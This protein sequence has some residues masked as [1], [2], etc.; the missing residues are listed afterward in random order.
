MKKNILIALQLLS[1]LVLQAQTGIGTPSPDP[2]SVLELKST[3]RGFLP[4]RMTTNQRNTIVS[5]ATG[6]MIYNSDK[7][8]LEWYDGTVWY[9]GCGIQESSGGSAVVSGYSCATASAGTLTV[10]TPVSGVTQTIT[11]AVATVGSY[12]ISAIANGVT[13][14][15]SGTFAGTGAQNIVL[16]ATGTPIAAETSSFILNTSPV[17]NFSRVTNS[18]T[19]NGS[20]VVSGYSCAT[21]SAGTLTAG[22]AATGVTQ[23]ITATVGTVGTYSIS[24]I[25]NG[26]TFAGSGTFAGTGAQNVVLTATGTPTA[27]ETSSFVLNTSPV[28]NFSRVTNSTTSNGSAVVSGYS[29]SAASAGAMTAGTAV[30]GVTQTITATVTTVGTYSISAIANGVTFADS[31]TFTGTGAQNVVLT[32]TGIPVAAETS[33]FILSIIPNC[34]F[35]RVITAAVANAICDGSVPTVV[36]PI[37]STTGKVWMDR[38]LGASRAATSAT[39]YQ[40]YGGL[41]QWGRG[42]DGHASITWISSTEGMAV[43]VTTAILAITD[44]PGNALFI[45]SIGALAY[46]WRSTQNNALW[47]GAAGINN[48]C[49][50][51]YR[52][53]TDAELTAEVTAYGITNYISA[54]ASPHK[55]V[56]AGRRRSDG[57]LN[58]AGGQSYY[59]SSTVSGTNASIRYFLSG[60]AG[61]FADGRTYGF[62]VRCLKD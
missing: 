45:T 61:S 60:S 53:P 44:S 11:A 32:G 37:T 33:S 54:Y 28:C 5:P 23:T 57:A 10:G 21:D 17:C 43:N 34:S 25:A 47:Q 13:F 14:K 62:S 8:C 20:A 41:Y 29:C 24:A 59:W 46:D 22:T 39:D 6:L 7:N 51:G 1:C 48:P 27:A 18:T 58:S 9:S 12:T 36:V 16:T 2:S 15:G 38:N 26:V 40:A 35:S 31:G 52:V 19:S 3:T 56:V 4:P 42:N 30:S 50:T 55:F 49:P